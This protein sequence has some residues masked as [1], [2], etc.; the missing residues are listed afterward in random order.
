MVPNRVKLPVKNK[1]VLSKKGKKKP[2]VRSP[3]QPYRDIIFLETIEIKVELQ[4]DSKRS[5]CT[6]ILLS[7]TPIKKEIIEETNPSIK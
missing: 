7:R 1:I 3:S 6:R 4:P 2:S 5:S